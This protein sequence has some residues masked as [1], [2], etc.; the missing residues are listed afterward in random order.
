MRAAEKLQGIP[1]V[2][3][4]DHRNRQRPMPIAQPDF[5]EV[6]H[7]ITA[8]HHYVVLDVLMPPGDDDPSTQVHL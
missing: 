6:A 8:D 5:D 7:A 1:S 3:A 2:A 4:N